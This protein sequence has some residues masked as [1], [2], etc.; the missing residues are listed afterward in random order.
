MKRIGHVALIGLWV[1]GAISLALALAHI[2][3]APVSKESFVRSP[4][5]RHTLAWR[6]DD[7]PSID[8]FGR[9]L[10][11]FPEARLWIKRGTF[12]GAEWKSES[13]FDLWVSDDF[14]LEGNEPT[15]GFDIRLVRFVRQPESSQE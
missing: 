14:E 4:S 10:H 3:V 6:S 5:G 15:G 11:L 8:V 9:G 12:F 13:S 1:Y 7:R 2:F